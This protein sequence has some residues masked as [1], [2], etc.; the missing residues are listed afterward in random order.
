M[1]ARE[2]ATATLLRLEEFICHI[3]QNYP[4]WCQL[5]GAGAAREAWGEERWRKH[6][7]GRNTAGQVQ[8]ERREKK[9][10]KEM[11]SFGAL[12]PHEVLPHLLPPIITS[13]AHWATGERKSSLCSCFLLPRRARHVGEEPKQLRWTEPLFPSVWWLEGWLLWQLEV[14]CD[15]GGLWS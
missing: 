3:S 9:R 10:R 15:E 14:C 1:N 13:F 6:S 12:L 5:Q 2:K 11:H 8:R 4:C 7:E